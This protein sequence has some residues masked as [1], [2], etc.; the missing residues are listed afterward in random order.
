LPKTCSYPGAKICAK[1]L[2]N[3]PPGGNLYDRAE[4]GSAGQKG[5]CCVPGKHLYE[6]RAKRIACTSRAIRRTGENANIGQKYRRTTGRMW[7]RSEK[8][9]LQ[10]GETPP[11]GNNPYEKTCN[12]RP[13][14][15][16]LYVRL[17]Q[18][19]PLVK[20]HT[21]TYRAYTKTYRAAL[22]VIYLWY[23]GRRSPGLAESRNPIFAKSMFSLCGPGTNLDLARVSRPGQNNLDLVRPSRPT[24][25]NKILISAQPCWTA[26]PKL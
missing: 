22:R 8:H 7:P 13:P 2:R 3:P 6:A 15:S 24:E 1:S 10:T 17:A 20:I 4:H 23:C 18:R 14:G 19:G 9:L 11:R 26:S 25:A 5:A 21:K 16:D 12:P